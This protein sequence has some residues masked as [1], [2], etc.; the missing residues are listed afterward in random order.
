RKHNPWVN[1]SNL[2]AGTTTLTSS[3]LRM[4]DFPTDYTTLPTVSIVV[5]NQ[6]NDM[7]NGTN[8]TTVAT[9]DAWAQSHLDGYYQ[10]AKT[11][12]SLLILTF[13]ESNGGSQGLTTPS[14]NQIVTVFA[15]AG[16]APGAYAEGAGVTH[17]NTM[18]TLEDMYG[19][20]HAGA[21]TPNATAAGIGSSSITDLF[22]Q[23][24]ADAPGAWADGANWN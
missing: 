15:G 20:P 5:P 21:Q 11:H 14:A 10:W 2:P 6:N 1:F 8:P 16:I 18:R 9:G 23:W 17:V 13:D 19:L 7:H 3:N 12:N 24:S 22:T 4:I